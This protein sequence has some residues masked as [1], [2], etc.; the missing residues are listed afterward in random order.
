MFR[1][2]WPMRLSVLRF[3]VPIILVTAGLPALSQIDRDSSGTRPTPQQGI[4]TAHAAHLIATGQL[5][6]AL[7]ELE[8]LAL[9]QPEPPGV[10]LMLG[11]AYYQQSKLNKA[12][13]AFGKALTQDPHDLKSMQLL[14]ITLFRLGRSAEAIPILEQERSSSNAAIDPD[15]LLGMCYMD[16]QRYDDARR[17]IASDAHLP[18]ESPTA[19]L[20]T[21]RL[22][23]RREYLPAAEDAGKKA[24]A[25]NPSL[26]LGHEL[27]GEIALARNDVAQAIVDFNEERAVN[28]VYGGLYERLGD[29]YFHAGDYQLALQELERAVLLE[30]NTTGP[31]ILLGKV[32]LRRQDPVAATTYLQRALRMDPGNY[33]THL[34]LGQAYQATGRTREAS[35]EFEKVRQMQYGNHR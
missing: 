18:P 15:Y 2:E 20:L 4:A 33:I 6:E 1:D 13:K 24:L 16:V 32:L 26:P 29:A 22:L 19:Y 27:I 3:L 28:P 34:L 30:P 12:E 23:L 31:Y 11:F 8:S 17:A 21:A 14:S 35:V 5:D 9:E 10:E 25:L 7:K